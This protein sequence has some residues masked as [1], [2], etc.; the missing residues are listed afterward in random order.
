MNITTNQNGLAF[1]NGYNIVDAKGT[2]I[3]G[4]SPGNSYFKR[5]T[6][7]TLITECAKK[8]SK[9][10]LMIPDK[11]AVHT[12]KAIGYSDSDA[13]RKARLKCNALVNNCNYSLSKI[14]NDAIVIA[15]W[16]NSI[17]NSSEYNNQYNYFNEL[18][19]TNEAF[20]KD[21]RD[22]TKNVIEKKIKDNN[23]IESAIDE[24]VTYLLS[25]L[26]FITTCAKMYGPI[27]YIYHNHWPIYENYINGVYDGVEKKDLGFILMN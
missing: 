21:V 13:E 14:N 22:T 27:G 23:N 1:K 2:A 24:G 10:I 12:Y 11:P 6:I 25:E 16:D 19:N 26:P 5:E 9:I 8:F 17:V 18:Y 7:D 20:R 3:I 4:M 15:K